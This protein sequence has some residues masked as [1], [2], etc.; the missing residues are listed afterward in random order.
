MFRG[1]HSN[2][3]NMSEN[4]CWIHDREGQLLVELASTRDIKFVRAC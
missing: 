4:G 1:D 2:K 3:H